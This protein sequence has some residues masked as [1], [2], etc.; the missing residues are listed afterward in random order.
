MYY[1]ACKSLLFIITYITYSIIYCIL[2]WIIGVLNI[3]STS[4]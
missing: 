3:K 1:I 4:F 2:Y